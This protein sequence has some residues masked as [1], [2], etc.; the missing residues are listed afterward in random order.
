MDVNAD[1]GE[2]DDT[3]SSLLQEP[4]EC[5]QTST[6]LSTDLDLR[7]E[8]SGKLNLEAVFLCG[9]AEILSCCHVQFNRLLSQI[10]FTD[11]ASRN[12]STRAFSWRYS[13]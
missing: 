5:G 1:P 2:V 6:G 11:P 9:F 4:E 13:S 12:R 8:V 3:E 10:Y 7:V